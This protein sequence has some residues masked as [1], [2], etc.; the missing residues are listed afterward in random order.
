MNKSPFRIIEAFCGRIRLGARILTGL[1]RK[2]LS[3]LSPADVRGATTL[4]RAAW[5][6]RG[7][8]RALVAESETKESNHMNKRSLN[9]H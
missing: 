8:S 1:Y 7:W 9:N 3:H 6:R 5:K 2:T 4:T